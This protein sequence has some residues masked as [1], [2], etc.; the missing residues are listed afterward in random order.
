M[1]IPP[2]KYL[3]TFQ[4]AADR[5]SFKIAAEQLCITPSAVSHQ[6]KSLEEHLGIALFDRG[7]RGLSL[8]EAGRNYLQHMQSMFA[9]LEVVTEQ[10]QIH[11]GRDVVRLH[12]PPFFATELL[13]PRLPAFLESQPDLDIHINTA[14]APLQLHPL[15]A[16]ISIIVGA[17]PDE[18][19]CS[20]K[21]FSQ[22]FV[23]ACAPQLLERLPV[24]A[25]EDLNRHTL[26]THEPRRD[27][28]QRWARLLGFDLR[29]RKLARFDTM[30]A[31]A[32]AAE[33]GVGIALV[34]SALCRERFARGSLVKLF[35][36]PLET[37]E[38]YFLIVRI[39][40]AARAHIRA[41]TDWLLD[42][43]SVAA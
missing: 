11:H 27:G 18:E 13:L 25:P 42:E 6:I 41:L 4:L 14:L 2:L 30:C 1:R 17:A 24:R 20:H 36:A 19:H 32:Q 31:A 39:E 7:P 8:T 35:D 21:L 40:D 10:L 23:P 28:W 38:N 16:D 29:P 3:K 15:E 9:R 43:F 5:R 37:G 12:M 22:E 34:S 26:I 33:H